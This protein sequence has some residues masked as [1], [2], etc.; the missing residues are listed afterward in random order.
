MKKV[1]FLA[2]FYDNQVNGGAESNDA[3]LIQSLKENNIALDC[4]PTQTITPDKIDKYDKIILSNFV[5]L[6]PDIK[7]HIAHSCKYII[8]EHDHKYLITRD[9]SMFVNFQAPESKIVNRELYK[10]ADKVV[11]LSE[12]CKDILEKTLKVDNVHSIGTSLWS[13]KKLNFIKDLRATASKTK[14][15]AILDSD[16]PTKGSHAA[17]QYCE[18]KGWPYDLIS[19]V[20]QYEFLTILSEYKSLVFMPQVLETFCRLVAEAKMLNCSVYTKRKMIGFMSEPFS[21]QSGFELI[22]T[23][24]KKVAVALEYFQALIRE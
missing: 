22:E 14:E 4:A 21:R 24:E 8:Y 18:E 7:N 11:V 2:D 3:V 13:Q 15:L 5:F 23:L 12:I 10:N 9:P 16:N 1:L 20:D 17:K 6:G 19:S